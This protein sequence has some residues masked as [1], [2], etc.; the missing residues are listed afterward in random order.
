MWPDQTPVQLLRRWVV[1]YF[2]SHDRSVA[3]GFIVPTYA[4]EI[5]DHLFDGRDDQFFIF[6][7]LL[8][9]HLVDLYLLSFGERFG[10]AL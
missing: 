5:G 3:T 1:D 10:C 2:N 6:R 7:N 8:R 4:L 9:D